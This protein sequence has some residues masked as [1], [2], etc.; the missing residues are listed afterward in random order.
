MLSSTQVLQ[1]VSKW[2][3][4]PAGRTLIDIFAALADWPNTYDASAPTVASVAGTITLSAPVTLV[5]GVLAITGIAVPQQFTD[6]AGR[7]AGGASAGFGGRLTV[8]PTGLF[9]WTAAGN[10][11]VAGLAVVSKSL[12]FTY[13]SVTN[14]W[15]PSYVA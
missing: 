5:S 12:D 14:K 2:F 15:Y 3:P 7:T 11:A 4:G 1:R 10:I 6:A 9:T 8:I 13:D